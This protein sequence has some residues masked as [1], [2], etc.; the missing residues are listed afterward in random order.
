MMVYSYLYSAFAL[1]S[2]NTKFR[3]PLN[4]FFRHLG[5]TQDI[6][7]NIMKQTKMTICTLFNYLIRVVPRSLLY[8]LAPD[9]SVSSLVTDQPS[10]ISPQV[11]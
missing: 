11:D 7:L 1:C 6:S 4:N 10:Q 8:R 9:E 3:D 5:Y 2:C